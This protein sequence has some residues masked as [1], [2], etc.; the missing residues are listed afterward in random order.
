MSIPEDKLDVDLKAKEKNAII[1]TRCILFSVL[2][3]IKYFVNSNVAGDTLC[4][5]KH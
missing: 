5:F 2:K 4:L 1:I 3:K